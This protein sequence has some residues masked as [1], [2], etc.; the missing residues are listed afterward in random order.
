MPFE[1][2]LFMDTANTIKSTQSIKNQVQNAVASRLLDKLWYNPSYGIQIQE[3]LKR[4]NVS[5]YPLLAKAAENEILKDDR[6][7]SCNV[8]IVA[9]NLTD[10]VNSVVSI[11]ITVSPKQ[12]P[13][14]SIPVNISLIV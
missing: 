1:V 9:S 10:S 5:E 12:F 2:D 8:E 4:F 7:A 11:S 14:D 6:I 13:N 3:K